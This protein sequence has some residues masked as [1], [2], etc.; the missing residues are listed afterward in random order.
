M[1]M[2][3]KTNKIGKRFTEFMHQKDDQIVHG[4]HSLKG[5]PRQEEKGLRRKQRLFD[6]A[7][8]FS[9]LW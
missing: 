8:C 2:K 7:G 3:A 1:E 5:V 6:D 9:I 4:G